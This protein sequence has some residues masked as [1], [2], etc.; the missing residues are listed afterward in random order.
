MKRIIITLITALMMFSMTVMVSA[1]ELD[2]NEKEVLNQLTNKN[3]PV[4]I[5][6][7]YLNQLEN[8]LIRDD[9]SVAKEDVE[10]V[11]S[12]LREALLAQ[13]AYKQN[14]SIDN[15]KKM[16]INAEK[17]GSL[18][19]LILEYDSSVGKFY[20][21]DSEGYIVIDTVNPIKNT[22]EEKVAEKEWNF[23]VEIFFAI[24]VGLCVIGLL[25]NFR[26]WS[27][28]LRSKHQKEYD[29]EEDDELE[30]ASR[31]TRRA[32]RQTFTYVNFKEILKYFYVPIIMGL[33]VI[34]I[35]YAAFLS[36][37]EMWGSASKNFLNTQPIYLTNDSEAQ[38]FKG[39]EKSQREELR[40]HGITIP[41]FS[42]RYGELACKDL[43][44][45]APV[46]WGDRPEQLAK[47]AG[48]YIGSFLP[49]YGK[50]ILIG[51]H[52]TTY[53]ANLEKV[54]TGD[55]FKFTTTYGIFRYKVV[56]TKIV[57]KD[58][59]KAYDLTADKEQLVLYTCYPY[60]TLNGTKN[61]RMFVYLDRV[62]GPSIKK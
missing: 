10:D 26:R 60:G 59:D 29:D 2:K 12:Y 49:G 27:R 53:F 50:T 15:F 42:Q 6:N 44:L 3:F 43:K 47:G 30:V 7:R 33:I 28:K 31:K 13:K 62:S 11:V 5:E 14:K 40:L 22:G 24:A 32:R 18:L 48:H 46:Y 54:K 38:P 4:K 20:A 8:Y 17:A 16:Y 1:G 35:G 25:A 39:D 45:D 41:K 51:A 19:H 23:S 9:V 34:G 58:F 52:N 55:E 37:S 36:T 57:D 61:Q 21:L 56:D